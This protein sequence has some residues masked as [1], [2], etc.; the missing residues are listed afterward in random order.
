MS[1]TTDWQAAFGFGPSTQ[2]QA[3]DDDL[4]F[5][6]WNESTKGLADL[7]AKESKKHI[8]K[9]DGSHVD[10]SLAQSTYT[11]YLSASRRVCAPPGFSPNHV[12]NYTVVT[13]PIR[14]PQN[15]KLLFVSAV[16]IDL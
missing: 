7:M 10:G 3:S 11:N 5:D 1:T 9:N 8:V 6:P 4:G 16:E 15:G 12:N 2:K 13:A 14:P